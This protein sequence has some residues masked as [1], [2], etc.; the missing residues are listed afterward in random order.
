MEE[1]LNFIERNKIKRFLNKPIYSSNDYLKLPPKLQKNKVVLQ[2]MINSETKNRI[3]SL[4]GGILLD[5]FK[6]NPELFKKEEIYKLIDYMIE[7]KKYEY[8]KYINEE[9]ADFL[10]EKYFKENTSL[11]LKL[12]KYFSSAMM[13]SLAALVK[14]E[15]YK[16]NKEEQKEC[17]ADG[18]LEFTQLSNIA[19][20]ELTI[21]H[22]EYLPLL[23]EN[24]Y[25][26]TE[27]IRLNPE[28]LKE[29]PQD[30]ALCSGFYF[31]NRYLLYSLENES[32]FRVSILEKY[33]KCLNYLRL[34][35][36]LE[37]L[38]MPE[39]YN[40]YTYLSSNTIK[41]I[42]QNSKYINIILYIIKDNPSYLKYI[43]YTK[44]F[45][46]DNAV[47]ETLIE[48]LHKQN[49][50]INKLIDLIL[51]TSLLSSKS[52]LR[53][54]SSSYYRGE[55]R[56]NG[57]DIYTE[58]QLQLIRSLSI[59]E[60]IE[61]MKIDITYVY[62]DLNDLPSDIMV[63]KERV[64]PLGT[65]HALYCAREAVKE[66]FAVISADDFY[67]REAFK[68]LSDFLDKSKDFGVI[69]YKIGNTIPKEGIVKRGICFTN[70]GILTDIVECT[71]ERKNKKIYATALEKDEEY[72][73]DDEVPVSMLMYALRPNIFDYLKED[74]KEF[75]KDKDLNTIEY[76]LPSVL[77]EAM[78]KKVINIKLVPTQAKWVGITYKNDLEELKKT[79]NNLIEKGE[80]PKKL[81]G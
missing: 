76:L 24:G 32:N 73:L 10:Y 11:Y 41:E 55:E 71:V 28:Y 58:N 12:R 53:T 43:G 29:Y 77:D 56:V 2:K 48:Y 45:K 15:V 19:Q 50:D 60:I 25:A 34:D 54:N 27:F 14:I 52:S 22:P 39:H 49:I 44:D 42:F 69:G 3:H 64:K 1:K 26:F 74:I 51:R 9:Y 36:Q 66:D 72:I 4:M 70:K 78:K 16:L 81:W 62:Q 35:D 33:P 68:D 8:L 46:K 61:L 57:I 65:A 17:F 79:I 38:N 18:L 30:I 7:C 59:E 21:T 40:Y 47:S 23:K 31:G 13:H 6:D 5:V 20:A 67:G 80:Y 63:P 75:F 37:F